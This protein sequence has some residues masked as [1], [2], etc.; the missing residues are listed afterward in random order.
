MDPPLDLDDIWMFLANLYKIINCNEKVSKAC[1]AIILLNSMLTTY[2]EVKN[3]INY[4][5][6]MLIPKI[7]IDFFRS[8]EIKIKTEK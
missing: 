6:E 4:G 2:K 3:A 1:K 5:R 7:V 8:K